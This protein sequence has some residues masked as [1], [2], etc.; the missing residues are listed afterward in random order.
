[1]SRRIYAVSMMFNGCKL[2]KIVID[3]HYEK[4]HASSI[5]DEIILALVK[6]LDGKTFR[7][8]DQD[9][10]GFSYFVNDKLELNEKF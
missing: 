9:E 1:M 10:D 7:P 5:T 2:E 3:P 4:K 6:Q 8:V